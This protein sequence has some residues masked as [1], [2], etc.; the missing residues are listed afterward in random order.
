[1]HQPPP[2][3]S[4]QYWTVAL[5][6]L[7]LYVLSAFVYIRYQETVDRRVLANHARII[8]DDVWAINPAGVENYLRL[9]METQNF[10]SIMVDIPGDEHFISLESPT[11]DGVT[12]LFVRI[13]LIPTKELNETIHYKNLDIGT[14]RVVQYMPLIY[15]LLNMLVLFL[16]LF[17]LTLLFF[18]LADRHKS[19]E[20]LVLERTQSLLDS[21]RRFHDLVNL[22]PEMVVETDLEGN[23]RYANHEARQRFGMTH[24][25]NSEIN[26]FDRFPADA[27]TSAIEKF[28]NSL[29]QGLLYQ[30]M[31]YGMDHRRFPALVRS[32]PILQEDKTVGA[33]LLLIDITERQRLEE[34]LNRDQKMKAI[35]LMAGGVAHDLNNIL[36]GIVSYP[37]ILML[38]MDEENPLRHPLSIIRKAG[39]DASEV[40]ADLLTVARGSRGDMQLICPNTIVK[41]YI[42]SPDFKETSGRYPLVDCSFFPAPDL[43]PIACSPIHMRKCLMNLVAN[44]FEAIDGK[45]E[46]M[47]ITENISP[48]EVQS[49]YV[50]LEEK[51]PYIRITVSDTGQGIAESELERI[52][53]P[54]YSKKVLGRSGTGLGLTVVWNTVRDH[55]GTT[56]VRSSGKGTTFELL[57]PAIVNALPE[58]QTTSPQQI[59]R[60]QGETILVIDDE[61]HQREIAARLLGSLGYDV[62]TVATGLEAWCYLEHNHADLVILDM[63]MGPNQP[64]GK[65]VYKK[66]LG[67]CPGQKAVIASGY[68]EDDDVQKTLK[69]GAGAFVSKP[70]TITTISSAVHRVLRGPAPEQHSIKE[71]LQ[72]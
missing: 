60:G 34:Q 29:Q 4:T 61:P 47:I 44:G 1:M 65:E 63:L 25:E 53:E 69:M 6:F 21:E 49:A 40:V 50:G 22:L 23:I 67:V 31:L 36:S 56:R 72:E 62:A 30:D 14:I 45:G 52:F 19:L 24:E 43:L 9:A 2:S 26:L 3:K 17:L 51:Q 16:L 57:F 5:I 28:H 12:G 37:E 71:R 46:V 15:P 18:F 41:N 10:R 55:G 42:D 68:A 59:Y 20:G 11:P 70:Y 66:I 64:N 54:F 13:G 32:A 33:R 38:D 39:L 48:E 7:A 8:A 35:G 58:E 27:R